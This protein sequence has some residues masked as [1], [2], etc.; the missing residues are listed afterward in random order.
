[1]YYR[2]N[3]APGM[4]HHNQQLHS[5]SIT[6]LALTGYFC[7][8]FSSRITGSHLLLKTDKMRLKTWPNTYKAMNFLRL[9]SLPN[10]VYS[11]IYQDI[12]DTSSAT[13]QGLLK[14]ITVRSDKLS[15]DIQLNEV[16]FRHISKR[17]ANA[18]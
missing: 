5:Q 1:M 18:Y 17:Q 4:D 9:T 11:L 7:E 6:G 12:P 10:P 3:V 8:Y 13:P 15:K 14:A 2:E 16:L